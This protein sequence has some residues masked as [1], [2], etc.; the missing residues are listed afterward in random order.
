MI[1]GISKLVSLQGIGLLFKESKQAF[2]TVLPGPHCSSDFRI[3]G[4]S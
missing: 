2:G 3:G 4:R 1:H